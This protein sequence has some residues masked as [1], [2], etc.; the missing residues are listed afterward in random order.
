[1][2]AAEHQLLAADQALAAAKL[3][4]NDKD[5]KTK[6]AA[7]D[8]E[9]KRDQA[10]K[11]FETART[12]AAKEPS[13]EYSPL[14]KVYPASSSGRRLALARWIGQR[15][16]PAYGPG[17]DQSD[18]AAAFRRWAR[19]DRVRLRSQWPGADQPGLA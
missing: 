12:A 9:T 3:A 19:A 11:A 18:L 15:R 5:E 6:Q 16:Q 10:N 14:D 4:V 13:G 8:A 1:M 2:L 7:K 17:G